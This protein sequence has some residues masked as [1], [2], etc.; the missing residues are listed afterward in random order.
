MGYIPNTPEDRVEMLAVLGLESISELFEKAVPPELMMEG[1]LELPEP[2]SE[3]EALREAGALAFANSDSGTAVSFLGA[4]AY[5]HF[6]PAIVNHIISRPEFETA[7]TPYQAEVSQGTLQ[8]IFEFQSM[9][10]MLTG[11]DVAN[12]SVYDGGSA[13]AEAALLAMDHTRRKKLVVSGMMNPHYLK[14]MR[15]YTGPSGGRIEICPAKNGITDY[16]A[17][18][19]MIDDETAA[20]FVQNPNFEG[21]IEDGF[22]VREAIT[23][24]KTLL[25]VSADPIS[26]PMITPPGEYGADIAVGEGQPLGIPLGYGGPYLG[27][28]AAS[29]KFIRKMP[30]RLIGATRDEDGRR[31]YVMTLQTREQHIRREKATSNICTNQALCALAATVYMSLIGE[32]GMKKISRLCFDKSHYLVNKLSGIDSVELIN[33]NEFFREFTLRLPVKA[34]EVLRDMAADGFLAGVPMARFYPERDRDILIAVTEK[35][36]K[37]EMDEFCEALE[38]VIADLI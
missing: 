19:D 8:A 24:R 21:C 6:I 2:L 25:V 37:V 4:G 11:M 34:G 3:Y 17:L 20:V 13:L 5:D 7:Y 38:A 23:D 9:I 26:L 10:A 31:G 27:L 33:G 22:A 32:S 36:S 1:E 35:R 15:T 28:F 30:G 14:V 29:K 18:A 16:D 12:A